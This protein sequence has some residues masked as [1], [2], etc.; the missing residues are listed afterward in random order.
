MLNVISVLLWLFALWKWGDWKNWE[1]YYGTI[2]FFMLGDFLYL[3]LLSDH[4]PMWK[5]TP[6]DIFGKYDL[7]NTHISLAIILIKYPATILI[8]LSKFPAQNIIRQILYF[9]FWVILYGV[10]ELV[11]LQFNN[12]TYDNGWTFWWSVFFNAVMFFILWVHF[13]KPLVAWLLSIIFIIYLWQT[14]D[15]PGMVFR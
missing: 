14:F 9:A 7:A 10:N 15:V 12:I 3:Y 5:Y 4:Y 11:D 6:P 1:K 13:K 2:L 8:F